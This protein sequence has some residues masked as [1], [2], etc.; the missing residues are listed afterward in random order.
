MTPLQGG[1]HRVSKTHVTLINLAHFAFALN[2]LRRAEGKRAGKWEMENVERHKEKGCEGMAYA[3]FCTCCARRLSIP[4][5]L[6]F[7]G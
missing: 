6:A 4:Q 7:R 3:P 2:A 5:L 1:G